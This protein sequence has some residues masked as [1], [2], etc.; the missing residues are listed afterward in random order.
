MRAAY[1]DLINNP[2]KIETILL[3]GAA[4]ARQRGLGEQTKADKRKTVKTALPNFK[5]YR[6]ADGRFYFKL[7]DAQGNLL[8]QSLGFASPKEAAQTIAQLQR[9]GESALTVHASHL[10]PTVGDARQVVAALALLAAGN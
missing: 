7:V 3:A 5:Q 1:E 9:E 4:K 8:L 2:A 10:Q 6:E